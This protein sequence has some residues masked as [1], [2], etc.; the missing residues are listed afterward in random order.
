MDTYQQKVSHLKALYHL[1]CADNEL[2]QEEAT[3]IMNVAERL[4]V[5]PEELVDFDGSEPKLVLPDKQYKH[6]A[7]FHRLVAV[8]MIDNVANEVEKKYCFDL[9]VKMGL[10]PNAVIEVIGFVVKHGPFNADPGEI[11]AIFRKYL[12]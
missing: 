2:S 6:Y 7:V 3:Y 5:D 10:H 9:G 12:S 11:L 1:A 8:I 4:G